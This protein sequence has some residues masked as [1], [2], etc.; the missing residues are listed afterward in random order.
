MSDKSSSPWVAGGCFFVVSSHGLSSTCLLE[1]TCAQISGVSFHK[2][3]N[4]IDQAPT[5]MLSFNL[6]YILRG[7]VSKS[8]HMTVLIT[9][10]KQR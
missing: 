9:F 2:D 1:C 7:S 10:T 8:S 6:N 5:P 3:T 4:P